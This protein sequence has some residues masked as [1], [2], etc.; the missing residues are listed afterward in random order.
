MSFLPLSLS[1]MA[2]CPVTESQKSF[3]RSACRQLRFGV[4]DLA[5]VDWPKMSARSSTGWLSGAIGC[6][7]CWWLG[8]D[9][10][11]LVGSQKP[12][13]LS[14]FL[15]T[16][17]VVVHLSMWHAFN[18]IIHF[19]LLVESF[20]IFGYA[21]STY[22]LQTCTRCFCQNNASHRPSDI[23]S[24]KFT[25]RL[26]PCCTTGDRC[27]TGQ[28]KRLVVVTSVQSSNQLGLSWKQPCSP[29]IFGP[30][31][32]IIQK[33]MVYYNGLS[34]PVLLSFLWSRG[35]IARRG[36]RRS[37]GRWGC[38]NVVLHGNA[39]GLAS[40][41]IDGAGVDFAMFKLVQ[42]SMPGIHK[43]VQMLMVL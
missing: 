16:M 35:C 43:Y 30:D 23:K 13:G 25:G 21:T 7:Q 8:T 5:V 14:R 15:R 4:W 3:S 19:N 2:F 6:L 24:F 42:I 33:P 27:G 28:S 37:A 32:S 36:S 26:S 9:F 39:D 22:K 29:V 41:K 38:S 1:P 10:S 12:Q 31:V 20:L 40:H 34:Y 11:K 17:R 18:S